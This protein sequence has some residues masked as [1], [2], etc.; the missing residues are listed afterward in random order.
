MPPCLGINGHELEATDVG[1][2]TQFVA[3]ADGRVTENE[4]ADWIRDRVVR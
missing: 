4:L 3:L 1:V 2:V